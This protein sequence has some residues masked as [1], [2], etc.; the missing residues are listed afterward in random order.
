MS[1]LRDKNKGGTGYS[2][3]SEEYIP[4]SSAGEY[5]MRPWKNK[6]WCCSILEDRGA[7]FQ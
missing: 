5:S 2:S 6:S 7:N 1:I 3:S 4:H